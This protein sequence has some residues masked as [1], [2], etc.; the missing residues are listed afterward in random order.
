MQKIKLIIF[1]KY[2]IK[3]QFLPENKKSALEKNL[4]K[5]K[6]QAKKTKEQEDVKK[7]KSRKID[8]NY[9]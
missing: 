7:N 2:L 4:E 8:E 3:Q 9:L 5:N 6:K 1:D